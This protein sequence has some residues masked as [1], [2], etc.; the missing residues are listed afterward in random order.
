MIPCLVIES[1][2]MIKSIS[3]P[4]SILVIL[5]NAITI[6]W[7]LGIQRVND[8]G[9]ER[10]FKLKGTPFFTADYNDWTTKRLIVAV[11]TSDTDTPITQTNGIDSLLCISFSQYY[12][13]TIETDP[14]IRSTIYFHKTSLEPEIKLFWMTMHLCD[15]LKVTDN[16]KEIETVIQKTVKVSTS[17]AEVFLA[18]DVYGHDV[19]DIKF[20][21]RGTLGLALFNSDYLP[22]R[23]FMG[24]IWIRVS[25]K[26][27][28]MLVTNTF[29]ADDHSL[30]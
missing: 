1:A 13:I 21:L 26:A 8:N 10:I 5:R 11:P 14:Q 9:P 29:T 16:P 6:F 24:K 2:D 19:L 3:F 25:F 30:L 7:P 23:L 15:K 20:K 22:I 4:E 28:P 18:Q 27:A 17:S 12:I